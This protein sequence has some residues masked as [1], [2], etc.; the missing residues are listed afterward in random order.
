MHQW[1]NNYIGSAVS[2]LA[3]PHKF[4]IMTRM[5][6]RLFIASETRSKDG[7]VHFKIFDFGGRMII[8]FIGRLA[9]VCKGTVGKPIRVP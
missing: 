8:E 4:E 9:G 1:S 7:D 2:F 3:G 6:K 5:G